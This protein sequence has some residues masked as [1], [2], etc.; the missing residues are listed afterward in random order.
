MR[1]RRKRKRR[2]KGGDASKISWED[3][4]GGK[5]EPSCIKT[6]KLPGQDLGPKPKC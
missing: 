2:K 4:L 1:K 6:S 3:K 5:S